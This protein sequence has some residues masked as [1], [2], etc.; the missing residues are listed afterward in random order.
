MVT[1]VLGC[2]IPV[3]F[4]GFLVGSK[5]QSRLKNLDVVRELHVDLHTV[6]DG[7]KDRPFGSADLVVTRNAGQQTKSDIV[8]DCRAERGRVRHLG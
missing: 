2:N 7:T 1:G 5:Q 3:F 6:G 8:F 4:C